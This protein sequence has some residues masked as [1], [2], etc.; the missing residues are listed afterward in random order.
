MKHAD[1][2]T[3]VRDAITSQ[4][5]GLPGGLQIVRSQGCIC[6]RRQQQRAAA[7]EEAAAAAA[8]ANIF[9]WPLLV[10]ESQN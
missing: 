7:A 1:A 2:K 9:T 6:T 3:F 8:A 5:N 10:V 4:K